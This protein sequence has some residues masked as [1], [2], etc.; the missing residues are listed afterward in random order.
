MIGSWWSFSLKL[1]R[2][3]RYSFWALSPSSE[4][5]IFCIKLML[6]YQ[7]QLLF[8]F[9]TDIWLYCYKELLTL[10]VIGGRVIVPNEVHWFISSFWCST[11]L[12]LWYAVTSDL[13]TILMSNLWSQLLVFGNFPS[14]TVAIASKSKHVL[15]IEWY[16]TTSLAVDNE[17]SIHKHVSLY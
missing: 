17:K 1:C 6:Y 3:S 4:T 7:V 10:C 11:L 16:M 13:L 14:Q 12:L 2:T 9:V 15:G 8:L 5:L